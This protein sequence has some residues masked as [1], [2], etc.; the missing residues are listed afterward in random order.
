MTK[1]YGIFYVTAVDLDSDVSQLPLFA[2]IKALYD[3][4]GELEM[5]N[6]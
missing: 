5:G 4:A 6:D 1:Q 3:Q 2:L